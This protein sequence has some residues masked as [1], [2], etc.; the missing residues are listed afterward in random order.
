MSP[1]APPEK[2]P[3]QFWL[4]LG[5]SF[6]NRLG[7]FVVPFLSLFLTAERGFSYAQAGVTASLVGLGSVLAGPIGGTLADRIGRK[8]TL[9]LGLLVASFFLLALLYAR[10]P[11][12][13]GCAVF[14]CGLGDIFRPAMHAAVA[15]LI[16]PKQ[17]ARAFGLLYWAHNFGF[18]LAMPLGGALAAGGYARLFYLDAGTSLVFAALILRAIAETRPA[19]PLETASE[20]KAPRDL[21]AALR[22][23]T[24]LLFCLMMMLMGV[25][26]LQVMSSLPLS[27]RAQGIDTKAYGA[28]ISINGFLIVGLQ[29]FAERVVGKL[30]A[31]RRLGMSIGMIGL[32]LALHALCKTP[33]QH[34]L[35]IASWTLGEIA[36]AGVAPAVV[37]H[38]APVHLRGAYQGVYGMAWSGGALLAPLLGPALLEARG[39]QVLWLS[40]A[41]LCFLSAAGMLILGKHLERAATGL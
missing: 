40:A 38:L 8:R 3:R 21:R 6:L 36:L 39:P 23:P 32:G 30:R 33:L 18:A 31:A 27:M 12:W 37:A 34:G 2:L 25:A 17:R 13:I 16:E 29:P 15:D 7:T 10:T 41:G 1:P 5:G 4:L 11:F 9:A 22:D 19:A 26:L 35:A 20:E 24:F 14:C 28:L